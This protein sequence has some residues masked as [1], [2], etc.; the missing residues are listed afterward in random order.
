[1]QE[2]AGQLDARHGEGLLT[3]TGH[4]RC[5][6]HDLIRSYA[7]DLAAAA[8]PPGTWQQAPDRLLDYYQHTAA[9]AVTFLARQARTGPGPAPQTVP[10]A[11][12]ALADRSRALAWARAER[13]GLLAC[14]DQATASG[15]HARVVALTAATACGLRTGRRVG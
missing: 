8:D 15:Q 11:V 4:R 10:A 14:L 5:G 1:M 13:D 12:P 7:R 3:E 2:P 9:L 6:M